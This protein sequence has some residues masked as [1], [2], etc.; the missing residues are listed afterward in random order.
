MWFTK[1]VNTM[2]EF[3]EGSYVSLFIWPWVIL[4]FLR[5]YTQRE[6]TLTYLI[7]GSITVLL[8]SCLTGLDSVALLYLNHLLVGLPLWNNSVFSG[9][10]D[11]THFKLAKNWISLLT[12]WQYLYYLCVRSVQCD[13]I[14]RYFGLWATF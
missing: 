9:P 5:T 11:H 2:Q 1:Q 3:L 7:K 10:T 14:G 12:K 4:T 6:N 8:T 13:Q